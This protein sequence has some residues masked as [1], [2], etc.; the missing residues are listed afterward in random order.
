MTKKKELNNEELAKVNGGDTYSSVEELSFLYGFGYHVEI[1]TWRIPGY[2]FTEAGSI[3]KKGYT[4]QNNVYSP[5]YYIE[6]EDSS[7]TGWYDE[8]YLQDT[9]YWRWKKVDTDKT[10]VTV[11]EVK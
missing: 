8:E 2:Q 10:P 9:T 7:Y 4:H 6:C 1:H 3:T 5:C 11:V